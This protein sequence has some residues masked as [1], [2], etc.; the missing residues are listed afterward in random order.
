MPRTVEEQAE[1]EKEALKQQ[2][3]VA[4]AAEKERR[5]KL[6]QAVEEEARRQAA[7]AAEAEGRRQAAAAAERRRAEAQRQWEE[8]QLRL[9]E[10][11]EQRLAELEEEEQRLAEQQAIEEH[12]KAEADKMVR[13][14]LAS[15]GFK[16]GV[17]E[18]KKSILKYQYPLHVAV[19]EQKADMVKL[20]IQ[21]GADMSVKNS[22]GRTPAD[23][24]DQYNKKMKGA[25]KE[26]SISVIQALG[27]A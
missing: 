7:A 17:N 22:S 5:A 4:E 26:K 24:A 8:E 6:Q 21:K 11:E 18:K 14:Y 23:K 19:K 15:H 10:E 2:Q 1:V 13:E 27:G 3:A 12:A 16:G 25:D 20:L 9:Q